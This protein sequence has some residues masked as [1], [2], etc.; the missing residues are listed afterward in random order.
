VTKRV[1]RALLFTVLVGALAGCYDW[2]DHD[3]DDVVI[4]AQELA[5]LRNACIVRGTVANRNDHTVRVFL[6]F[7]AFDGDDDFIGAAEA[8]VRDI[9]RDSSRDFES[10]RFRAFDGDLIPCDRIARVKRDEA[11]FRD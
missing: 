4:T 7:R 6:T 8:E 9:P 1:R 11:V 3:D 5:T 2:H 10:T